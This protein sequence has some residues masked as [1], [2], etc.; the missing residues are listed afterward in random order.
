MIESKVYGFL[1]LRLDSGKYVD[2]TKLLWR[3][4]GNL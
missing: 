1:K 3:Y 2:A 4:T